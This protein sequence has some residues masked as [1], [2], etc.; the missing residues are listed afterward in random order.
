MSGIQAPA[1]LI[2]EQT[3]QKEAHSGELYEERQ[4]KGLGQPV[5]ASVL[6][7]VGVLLLFVASFSLS[8]LAHLD[9]DSL[10][11]CGRA[12][13]HGIP[14]GCF[15][16]WTVRLKIKLGTSIKKSLSLSAFPAVRFQLVSVTSVP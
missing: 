14:Q 10:S 3:L 11:L 13:K 6:S 9:L 8:W 5:P 7:T 12:G 16:D 4:V 2:F 15:W 1:M